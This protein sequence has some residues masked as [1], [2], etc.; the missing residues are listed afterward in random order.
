MKDKCE[1]K[2][3]TVCLSLHCSIVV[4]G[5]KSNL[6]FCEFDGLLIFPNRKEEQVVFLETKNKKNKYRQVVKNRL[7]GLTENCN[8]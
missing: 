6:P 5:N 8:R 1:K 4:F 3:E 7:Y 2:T